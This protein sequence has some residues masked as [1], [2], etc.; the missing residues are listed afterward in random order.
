MV[1]LKP[2]PAQARHPVTNVPL[3]DDDGQPRPLLPESRSIWWDG[4]M[5]G[6]CSKHGATFTLEVSQVPDW[7]RDEVEELVSVEF[8]DCPK[9]SML[10]DTPEEAE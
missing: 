8:G 1:E 9:V 3:F 7:V 2:H 6:Y 5:V 4:V 10:I